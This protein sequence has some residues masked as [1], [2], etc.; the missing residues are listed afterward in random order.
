MEFLLIMIRIHTKIKTLEKHLILLMTMIVKVICKEVI[1]MKILIINLT[2]TKT[3]SI[4]LKV[5][6]IIESFHKK[7]L[8]MILLIGKVISLLGR[9]TNLK[10]CNNRLISIKEEISLIIIIIILKMIHL[11]S[12]KN[13]KITLINLAM[14]S[15]K[16]MLMIKEVIELSAQHVA[17]SSKKKH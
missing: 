6:T 7:C 8:S 9:S 11:S 16:S 17:V 13:L 12:H 1:L 15:Q 5:A 4:S 14:N 10:Y 3:E 2:L